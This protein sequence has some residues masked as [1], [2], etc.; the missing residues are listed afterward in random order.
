MLCFMILITVVPEVFTPDGN[1]KND[2]WMITWLGGVDP[3]DFTMHLF[4]EAGG[5]VLEMDGLRQDFDGGSLPDGVYWWVLR[6]MQGR[7]L[8]AG[9]LTIRRK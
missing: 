9:G 3:G 1:G 8:Q 6:D 5:K 2:T 4:N 7:D